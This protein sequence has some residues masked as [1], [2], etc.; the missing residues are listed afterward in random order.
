MKRALLVAILLGSQ[1]IVSA[2]ATCTPSRLV[3]ALTELGSGFSVA[4]GFPRLITVRVL[5]DCGSPVE[6]AQVVASFNNGDPIVALLNV[7][8]GEYAGTI[9]PRTAA[10]NFLLSIHA[11][12]KSFPRKPVRKRSC[13]RH[14]GFANRTLVPSSSGSSGASAKCEPCG[15]GSC[16]RLFCVHFY[17]LGRILAQRD[18]G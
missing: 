7:G 8:N 14:T 12:S 18:A 10:P 4:V 16:V 5:D 3:L 13:R 17:C 9:T 15:V 2:A 6:D 1:A 11:V